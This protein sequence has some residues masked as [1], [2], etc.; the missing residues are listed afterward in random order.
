MSIHRQP[1]KADDIAALLAAEENQARDLNAEKEQLVA[2]TADARAALREA[3]R[4]VT[5]SGGASPRSPS[6]NT[7]RAGREAWPSMLPRS[8]IFA[9][10][11]HYWRAISWVWRT[12]ERHHGCRD[13][14]RGAVGPFCRRSSLR[15][16]T[17]KEDLAW[18]RSN[19]LGRTA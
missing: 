11:D 19:D 2:A 6:G 17:M 7:A 12:V 13:R 1:K 3:E 18:L 16:S 10:A 8:K 5:R 4:D 14:G 15:R 9:A